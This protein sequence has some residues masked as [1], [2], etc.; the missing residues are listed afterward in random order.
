VVVTYVDDF[1]REQ[2]VEETFTIEVTEEPEA[3]LGPGAIEGMSGS[4]SIEV[5]SGPGAPGEGVTVGTSN[6]GL[7][8]LKGLLGLG[9]SPPLAQPG[10]GAR[11]GPGRLTPTAP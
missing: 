9:A 5:L 8:I 1:N 11:N 2:T 4:G 3:G 6:V 7:R 10:R